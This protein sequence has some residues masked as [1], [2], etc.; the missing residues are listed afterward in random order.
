MS[1]TEK[2]EPT[3]QDFEAKKDQVRDSLI[4][5]QQQEMF[6]LFV[7]NLRAQMEKA[8]KIQINADEMKNL[9]RSQAV[10]EQGE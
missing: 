6:G 9:T 2:Q 3:P 4:Q 5:N 8:G 7:S 1:V 10:P